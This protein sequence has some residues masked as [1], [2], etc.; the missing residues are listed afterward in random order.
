MQNEENRPLFSIITVC[1]NEEN[2]IRKVIESILNQDY[3][4]YEYLI[5]D[6]KS[7]DKTIDIICDYQEKF[8]GKMQWISEK[9]KGLYD[10][11]NKGIQMANGKYIA[12]I[13]ADD[14]LESGILNKISYFLQEDNPDILYGDSI[15]IYKYQKLTTKKIKKANPNISVNSLRN[16]MGVVH[17]SIF[18]R[19]EYIKKMGGFDINF[20]IGA[21]WDFLIRSVKSGAR[22][23]YI[24]EPVST[25]QTDGVSAR[26]HNKERHK[27]R[28]KNKMYKYIDWSMIKDYLR[29]GTMIQ[30]VIGN[31]N[32]V[33]LRYFYN[34]IR[35][36]L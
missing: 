5:I 3:L 16:G 27:I 12:F 18:T 17:Q 30:L 9:D 28:K 33:K 25:F 22:L 1:Y 24:E 23:K 15:N 2:N 13:N 19:T 6:G 10:A 11:M 7:N 4:D 14:V 31:N 26:V 29:I 21:D 36:G 32:Y 8:S 35:Y 34:K 20:K